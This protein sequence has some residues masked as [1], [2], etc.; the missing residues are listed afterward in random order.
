MKFEIG[1]AALKSAVPGSCDDA[2]PAVAA[3]SVYRYISTPL[4][5][6]LGKRCNS[7]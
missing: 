6:R 7:I 2:E 1:G 3:C 5:S 4:N